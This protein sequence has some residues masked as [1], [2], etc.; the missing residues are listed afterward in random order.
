MLATL[1]MHGHG[2]GELRQRITLQIAARYAGWYARRMTNEQLIPRPTAPSRTEVSVGLT[3]GTW[4]SP[5]S[6]AH[7][8]DAA[9]CLM[10]AVQIGSVDA[11]G[12]ADNVGIAMVALGISLPD[13]FKP[14]IV[15]TIKAQWVEPVPA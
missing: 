1:R 2:G 15:Q 3:D 12:F 9:A 10:H 7:I 5:G 11:E 6:P 14:M 13:A 4:A 8:Q